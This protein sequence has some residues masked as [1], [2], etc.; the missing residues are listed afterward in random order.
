M[1][2]PAAH[3]VALTRPCPSSPL[4][5][6]TGKV[7]LAERDAAYP[8]EEGA[9]GTAVAA[10]QEA[11][12]AAQENVDSMN[13]QLQHLQAQRADIKERVAE[14]RRRAEHIEEMVTQE[15]PH[16]RWVLGAWLGGTLVVP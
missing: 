9:H 3:Q 16:T 13:R 11:S 15:E 4:A 7:Q 1:S 2:T 6:L 10:L 5:A 14:L 8:A 12:A